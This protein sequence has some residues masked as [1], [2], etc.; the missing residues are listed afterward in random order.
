MM[1]VAEPPPLPPRYYLD[2]F[3]RL[4]SSVMDQYGDLLNARERGFLE[5]F[6][7]VSVDARCLFVRL[8]SRRGPLFRAEALHYPELDDLRAALEECLSRELLEVH[9]VPPVAELMGLM[10]RDELLAIYAQALSL[11]GRERKADVLSRVAELPEAA[12]LEAWRCWREPS[13]YLVGVAY[14]A[15]VELFQ[16]LFFGNS[17]QTLTEFVLS[18]LGISTF[19]NYS[20]DRNFRLFGNREEIEE[21]LTLHDLKVTY[22]EAVQ[23]GDDEAVREV[24]GILQEADGNLGLKGVRDRLRNRIARQLERLDEPEA[25]LAL[26][27]QSGL[28]PARERSAR[29]LAVTG[30]DSEALSL[31]E[32]MVES[33]WCEAELDYTRRVLPTLRKRLSLDYETAARD[34][35]DVDELILPRELPV[36]AAAARYYRDTWQQVHYVENLLFNGSFGLA[37]WEQIFQAVPGAFINPF[38][39]A[40]LDMY[41]PDFRRLRQTAL[42]RRLQYLWSC[43]LKAELMAAYERH[44]GVTNRWVAWRGLSAE[45]LASALEHIPTEHW[46]ACW[47]RILFDPEANRSGCPDLI[48]MD[49][50]RGYCLIEVKGPGD[51]LQLN[52]RRWLRFFQ[53]EKIPARVARVQWSD[54]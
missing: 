11:T 33:P 16:L 40:P 35:F 50:E 32:V 6:H 41:S 39:A 14:R 36:E 42:N 22:K 47:R 43:D 45:L 10:R 19:E 23:A 17:Y 3:G 25:A 49:P 34:R 9:E 54:A 29:L 12:V 27:S 5:C 38:Q 24:A 18:D 20:L 37:F 8:V 1:D 30:R 13:Q 4:C 2:N 51:Q 44:H 15:E 53:R 46:L 21:Y 7:S 52:Q 28:H 31:C 26:Y 48:A